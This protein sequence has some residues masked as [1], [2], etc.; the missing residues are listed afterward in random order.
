MSRDALVLDRGGGGD[1]LGGRVGGLD[2][3]RH[4]VRTQPRRVGAVRSECVDLGDDY[5]CG[6]R[7]G[8]EI[9]GREREVVGALLFSRRDLDEGYID[10][11]LARLEERA[12]V[13][14]AAR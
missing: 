8:D 2:N 10:A 11:D 14:V 1:L 9:F 3:R 4:L 6:P 7:S 13:A 5:P 12:Q